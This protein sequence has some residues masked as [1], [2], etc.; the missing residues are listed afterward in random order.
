MTEMVVKT[1]QEMGKDPRNA[2]I[3]EAIKHVTDPELHIDV[4][5]LELIYDI[6]HEEDGTVNIKMTFTSPLCPYGTIL[7]NNVHE[8]VKKAGYEN[9]IEVVIEPLWQP[10]DHVKEVLGIAH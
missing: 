7:V 3:I 2:K 5:N 8:E 6:Q 10:S 4:W 9:N 1:V